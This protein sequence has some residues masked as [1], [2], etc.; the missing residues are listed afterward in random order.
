MI[1]S[2]AHSRLI[3]NGGSVVLAEHDHS[4]IPAAGVRL[5]VS[6]T[7]ASC[8]RGSD[9]KSELFPEESRLMLSRLAIPCF[10]IQ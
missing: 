1:F 9:E 3:T 10:A 8:G 5:G 2:F 4:S 7:S 6:T